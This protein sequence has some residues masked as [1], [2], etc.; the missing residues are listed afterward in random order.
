MSRI[1]GLLPASRL[2]AKL[3]HLPVDA[4]ST[5]A[6]PSRSISLRLLRLVHC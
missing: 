4:M 2:A 3:G 5:V 6:N 1:V